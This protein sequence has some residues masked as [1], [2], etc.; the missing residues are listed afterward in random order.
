MG[1][2]R[3]LARIPRY[4]VL[5]DGLRSEIRSGRYPVG[6]QLPTELE[7]CRTEG[8]SRHTARDALRILIDE[9]LVERRQGAGTKVIAAQRPAAFVQPLGG[10]QE[11][12]Q[13]AR[14]ARLEISATVRRP[15]DA[16]EAA[17]LETAGEEPWA[18]ADGLRRRAGGEMLART[19]LF[20]PAR[21]AVIAGEIGASPGAVQELIERR[22]GVRPARIAQQITAQV[23]DEE[24]ARALHV[25]P[26]TAAL[27]TLRRYLD[28]QDRVIVASDSLHPA[29]RFAYEMT[30]HRDGA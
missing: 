12:M 9:G 24:A 28:E 11:L 13:Y 2:S 7:I 1:Y 18:V 5:A 15:L 4:H 25:K 10:P 8:V 16:W 29:D 6:A 26:G 17:W 23:L 19:R 21:F 22:W 20:I 30:Y 3:N 14:D 27:R